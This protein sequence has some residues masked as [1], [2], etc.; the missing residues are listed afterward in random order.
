MSFPGARALRRY[1]C[2]QQGHHITMQ[3]QKKQRYTH[4]FLH[5][6]PLA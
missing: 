1:G 3:F 5:P 2:G 4:L 6:P